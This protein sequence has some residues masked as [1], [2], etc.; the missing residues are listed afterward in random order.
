MYRKLLPIY[1]QYYDQ[2]FYDYDFKED[3]RRWV[4]LLVNI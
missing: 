2:N 3:L 4:Y 1:K